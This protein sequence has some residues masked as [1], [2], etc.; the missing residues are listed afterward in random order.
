MERSSW[1]LSSSKCINEGFRWKKKEDISIVA[2]EYFRILFFCE[3]LILLWCVLIWLSFM[4]MKSSLKLSLVRK[5]ETDLCY[6]VF[7]SLDQSLMIGW[8]KNSWNPERMSSVFTFMCACL[9]V[10]LSVHLL[11]STPFDLGTYF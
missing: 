3:G 8:R 2:S 1:D 9:C 7:Y 5:L 4:K 10:C 6:G 11:Q